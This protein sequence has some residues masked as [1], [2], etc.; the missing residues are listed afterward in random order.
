MDES[1][2]GDPRYLNEYYKMFKYEEGNSK[3]KKKRMNKEVTG[4]TKSS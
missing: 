2:E 3:V 1:A 4:F